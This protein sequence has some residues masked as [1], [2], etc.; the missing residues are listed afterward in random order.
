M[1]IKIMCLLC[2]F[3]IIV[4][5]AIRWEVGYQ[6]GAPR[7]IGV[8]GYLCKHAITS[9]SP[10]AIRRGYEEWLACRLVSQ[11][12][13][14]WTKQWLKKG[15]DLEVNISFFVLTKEM[16]APSQGNARFMIKPYQAT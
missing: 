14:E 16:A 6:E 11:K 2:F 8:F 1:L 12:A 3:C 5:A 10:G 9:E 15:K 7:C 4:L 13:E